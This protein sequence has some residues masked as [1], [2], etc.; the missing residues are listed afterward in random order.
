MHYRVDVEDPSASEGYRY[1]IVD[2]RDVDAILSTNTVAFV[3]L[4]EV[5]TKKA[6]WVPRVRIVRIAE[7]PTSS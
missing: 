1:Y 7:Q 2:Q 3:R 6:Y 4:T 5:N